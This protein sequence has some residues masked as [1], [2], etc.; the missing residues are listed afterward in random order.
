MADPT[1]ALSGSA[2]VPRSNGELQFAAP[3][4]SRAFGIVIALYEQGELEW[5]EFRPC[6]IAEIAA[7]GDSAHK[8]DEDGS[9][10]YG[11]WLA[12]LA[13]V[14]DEH[15]IVPA[16]DLRRRTE[17]FRSGARRDVY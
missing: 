14:L 15:G 12:A 5:D 2:A 13:A 8:H 7:A 1:L 16:D 3:W 10:Y 11:H 4:Q 6:L 9:A 17:E